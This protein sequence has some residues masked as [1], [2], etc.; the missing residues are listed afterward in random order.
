M[1]T[2]ETSTNKMN[3]YKATGSKM[4]TFGVFYTIVFGLTLFGILIS[5]NVEDNIGI[6]IVVIV[7]FL[8]FVYLCWCG[9]KRKNLA[10]KCTNYLVIMNQKEIHSFDELSVSLDRPVAALHKELELMIK[11]GLIASA[12]IDNNTIVSIK[13]Q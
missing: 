2:D 9:V 11:K 12:S 13:Q 10:K 6:T 1:F 7:M 8:L 4:F 3:G 5:G